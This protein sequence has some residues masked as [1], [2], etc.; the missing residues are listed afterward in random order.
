ME[1]AAK[2]YKIGIS[3]SYGG[4]NLGDEAILQS[5]VSQL[6]QS[7]SA[8]ITV[9]SR[10]PQDTLKRHDVDHAVAVRK[11]SRDE[12]IPEIGK[13]DLFIL[14]GGG[15]LYDSEARQYLREAEIAA[16]LNV[17]FMVY[18]V[19]VGPL[20]DT[21]IQAMVRD[22]LNK[23]S[24]ITVREKSAKQ[25][26]ETSGVRNEI[27]VT[28]D[29]AF[30]L[31]PAPLP[32]NVLDLEGLADKKQLVAMSVREPGGAAPDLDEASYV[33]LLSNAADFM[34]DRFDTDIVFV[35]MERE[36]VKDIQYSH[37]VISKMYFANRAQVLQQVYPAGQLL[38][39]FEHFSFAV[40]MRLHFLIFSALQGVPF[41]ALPYAAKVSGILESMGIDMPLLHVVT[42]GKLAAYID[43]SWDNRGEVKRLILGKLSDL[44]EAARRNNEI[45]VGL[46][47]D[48]GKPREGG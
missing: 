32:E 14:G 17:P 1:N 6:R 7:V 12:I 39:L 19:G 33:E 2:T 22:V 41:V 27:M 25:L 13:L 16:E 44:Q 9:F 45:A 38:S 21:N 46:L 4:L 40:G 35:P 29:P 34:V 28:A 48:A 47:K 37:A 23:A 43:R 18:A 31:S 24:A 15:I 3:G 11:M 20:G 5:M 30:L 26:L 8:E 36:E 10:N 42:A